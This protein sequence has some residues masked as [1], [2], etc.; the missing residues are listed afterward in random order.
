MT[1]LARKKNRLLLYYEAEE[2]ILG[3]QSYTL[4]SRTLT[5]AD[6]EDVQNMI[7]RLENEIEALE[8]RGTCR[9]RS[10]RIIPV[11]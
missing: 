4:G 3:S 2:K 1:T 11:D 8:T 10:A 6:L 5:R 9:R 7:K